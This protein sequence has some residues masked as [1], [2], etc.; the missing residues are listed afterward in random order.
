MTK[1][2]C[3][4]NGAYLPLDE[5]YLPVQDLAI[6]RGYGVFDFLRTY[7]GRPFKLPQHLD[8]LAN[9]ARLVGLDLPYSLEEIERIVLE[10]LAHNPLAEA[11]IRVVVTGGVSGDAI[12]PGSRPGLLVLVTPVH[13]YPSAC[14]DQ[15]IKVI[16]VELERYLSGAKT[17]N[18][19]PAIIALK[20][21]RAAGALEALYLNRQNHVLEGTTTNFFILRAGQL[22]TPRDD[23]LYGVTRDVVLELARDKFEV[24]ERPISLAELDQA[25]E[26]FI[27]ASNKEI[28]PVH[29]VNEVQIGSGR[30]GPQTRWLM[31]RFYKVT[32]EV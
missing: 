11:N 9:S 31:E 20:Q 5:A 6:L 1:P 32:R 25:D 29:H 16:T 14:Y 23:I 17:I 18:Y 2:I 30:P 3:Y 24:I 10:T 19:I 15:G 13:S 4:V 27:T 8:R 7:H 28:M 12:T 22:V 26:A 21:A